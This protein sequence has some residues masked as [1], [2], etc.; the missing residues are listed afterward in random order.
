VARPPGAWEENRDIFF[1]TWLLLH[2]GQITWDV[3]LELRTSSS[4][5]SPQ[6][7][8]VNSKIGMLSPRQYFIVWFSAMFPKLPLIMLA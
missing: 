1:F 8:Q 6:L 3:S 2:N 7:W 5:D 4:K